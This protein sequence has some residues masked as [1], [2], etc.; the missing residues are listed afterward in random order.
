MDSLT[1]YVPNTADWISYYGK[2]TNSGGIT[3]LDSNSGRS[4]S[5]PTGVKEKSDTFVPTSAIATTSD[6]TAGD[7]LCGES[8][9]NST[10]AD[11]Q[12]ISPV[13]SAV[14][15][16]RAIKRR[17]HSTKSKKGKGS[18]RRRKGSTQGKRNKRVKQ[19]KKKTSK[20]KKKKT[21]D[22]FNIKIK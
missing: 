6:I 1:L 14:A 19:K 16:A 9:D 4:H 12:V 7:N 15:Q 2:P 3:T 22:I 11:I 18:K 10:M 20:R 5:R 8:K 13:Q 17:R 21:R